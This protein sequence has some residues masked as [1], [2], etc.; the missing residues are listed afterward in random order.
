VIEWV[1][2][3][4]AVSAFGEGA[5]LYGKPRAFTVRTA[6]DTFCE[7]L[8]ITKP[9]FDGILVSAVSSSLMEYW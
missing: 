9:D 7:V 5:L 6:S 1:A 8:M 3:C 4:H 2:D